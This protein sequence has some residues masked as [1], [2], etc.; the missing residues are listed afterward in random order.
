MNPLRAAVATLALSTSGCAPVGVIYSNTTVPLDIDYDQTRL[1]Q[2]SDTADTRS[3]QY[4]IRVEWGDASI[5]H[6]A[7]EYGFEKIHYADLSTLSVLG[8][9]R[10]Q[11]VTI[12]GE[13]PL[14]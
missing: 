1:A 6:I 12:Y 13:R 3:I 7:Q 8:V 9:W 14:R 4:Y 2:L 11:F 5:G 10:Q